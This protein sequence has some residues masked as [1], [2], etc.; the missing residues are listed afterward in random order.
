MNDRGYVVVTGASTGIGQATATRLAAQGFVVF[1]G[2]R[3]SADAERLQ[4]QSLPGLRPLMIDVANGE[5]VKRAAAEVTEA[6]GNSGLKGLV[7]NAGVSF[8]GPLE[9]QELDEI[10]AMFDVN[11]LGLIAVTQ[12]FLALVRKGG[13]RIVNMSSVGGK[14]SVP[15]VSA[16][17]ATKFGVEAIS[18]ALRVELRPWGIK[19]ACIEPGSI[20]TPLWER[21]FEQFD[22][23]VKNLTPEAIELYGDLIPRMRK[24]TERTAKAGIPPARVADAVEHALTSRGRRHATWWVTMRAAKQCCGCCPIR[25]ATP[26]WRE[27]SASAPGPEPK[28]LTCRPVLTPAAGFL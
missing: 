25:A 4:S 20:A 3:K 19:V 12:A 1:A 18:D 24:L 17:S 14:I 21:G 26:C 16:Y 27:S 13:G 8:G 28:I 10:R 15:F 22:K 11:V 9:F 2:V 7:N 23:Q 5:S 6:V